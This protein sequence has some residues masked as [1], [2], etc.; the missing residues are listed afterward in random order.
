MEEYDPLIVRVLAPG[1][2][3]QFLILHRALTT[4]RNQLHH[5][6]DMQGGV[7]LFLIESNKGGAYLLPSKVLSKPSA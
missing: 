4:V 6:S 7:E 3:V 5:M 1:N 2:L